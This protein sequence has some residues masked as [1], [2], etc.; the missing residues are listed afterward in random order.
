MLEYRI[1]F[2]LTGKRKHTAKVNTLNMP[3]P[4]QHIDIPIPHGSR[5][6]TIVPDTVKIMYNIDIESTEKSRIAAML[7]M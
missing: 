2:A 7:K 1:Q 6:H 5:D 4:N 3:Y